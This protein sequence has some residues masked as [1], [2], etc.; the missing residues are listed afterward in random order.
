MK[1]LVT[2]LITVIAALAL[3]FAFAGCSEPQ[4]EAQ[5]KFT[6]DYFVFTKNAVASTSATYTVSPTEKGRE[7]QKLSVPGEIYGY[8]VTAVNPSAF[9]DSR[10]LKEITIGNGINTIGENAFNGCTALTSV[11][12][13]DTMVY[14]KANAFRNCTALQSITLTDGIRGIEEYAFEGCTALTNVTLPASLKM[15]ASYV[16]SGTNIREIT[17]PEGVKKIGAYAFY[18]C[19][20]LQNV[21]LPASLTA[22]DTYAFASCSSLTEILFPRNESLKLGSY[23]FAQSA[24]TKVYLPSNVILGEYTF[25]K[26]AWDD[27]VANPGEPGSPGLSGCTAIY[28]ESPEGDIGTNAFGYTWN[29]PDLGFRIYIPTGSMSYY[30]NLRDGDGSWYRCVVN[31]VN[32]QGGQYNVLQEYDIAEVFPDGFPVAK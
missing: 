16:F 18:A 10:T 20:E 14:L 2:M 1:K 13:P 23:A 5:E 19:R 11:T 31:S 32:S 3:C 17:I 8:K 27:S 4:P 30:S 25:M 15:I 21:S 28:Y 7:Q 9:K 26:L 6:T 29:R 24:L 22:I 12:F